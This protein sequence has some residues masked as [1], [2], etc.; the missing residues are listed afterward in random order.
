MIKVLFGS[1]PDAVG[2]GSTLAG[3]KGIIEDSVTFGLSAFTD[4]SAWK[5]SAGVG[6]RISGAWTF[7]EPIT[8][9]SALSS[10]AKLDVATA[11]VGVGGIESVSDLTVLA[12]ECVC[13]VEVIDF[14]RDDK[15]SGD[16]KIDSLSFCNHEERV[17]G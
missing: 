6:T 4:D 12:T 17:T 3:C 2:S 16:V 7:D 8:A 15:D 13:V 14:D 11:R 10:Q 5:R 1:D 9:C